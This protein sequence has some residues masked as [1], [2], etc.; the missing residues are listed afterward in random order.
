M[1]KQKYVLIGGKVFELQS[2]KTYVAWDGL[3]ASLGVQSSIYDAYARPSVYKVSAWEG[4]VRWCNGIPV[5]GV[6]ISGY[7]CMMFSVHGYAEQYGVRYYVEFTHR[8]N[9]AWVCDGMPYM[10]V[11]NK[12]GIETLYG[13]EYTF[14]D[15]EH[16]NGMYGRGATNE[17]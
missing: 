8:H 14:E 6:W 3:S 11:T 13:M 12:D 16:I 9:R 1:S 10:I 15:I 4:I 7:N 2:T 17:T 5:C